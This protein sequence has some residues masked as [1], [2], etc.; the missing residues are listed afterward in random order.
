[1]SSFGAMWRCSQEHWKKQICTTAVIRASS[2][3]EGSQ[4][5]EEDVENDS[6]QTHVMG[7]D[8]PNILSVCEV[9]ESYVSACCLLSRDIAVIKN[10]MFQKKQSLSQETN[11]LS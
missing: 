3:A 6:I 10:I 4:L 5:P 11:Y 7:I 8:I 1:M 2:L 9:F